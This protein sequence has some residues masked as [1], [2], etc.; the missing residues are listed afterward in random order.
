MHAASRKALAEVAQSLDNQISG[1]VVTAATLGAELFD[2]VEFLDDHRSLRVAVAE[3]SSTAQQRQGLITEVFEG[4]VSPATLMV[5][6]EAAGARWS[7]PRE[8]RVGLVALGRRALLRGAELEGTLE[9][10][11]GELFELSRLL[12]HHPELTQLLSERAVA[13]S[14]QRGLL[15]TVLYGKVS[16]YTEALA[17]QVIGRPE[18]NPIDDVAALAAEAACLRGR[19]VAKVTS[20]G[21]LSEKQRQALAQKLGRIYGAEMDVFTEVD[22]SLLGGMT[23]RVG[24]ERIDGSTAGKIRRLRAQLA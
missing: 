20:A 18:R 14:R 13:R 17:L 10:V 5:L 19:T 9:Q 7:T 21:P 3:A 1:S 8:F 16:K 15:A 23:I 6:K 22:E 11:E 4:K 24:D 12:E 2:A